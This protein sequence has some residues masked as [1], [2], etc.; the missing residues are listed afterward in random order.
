[1]HVVSIYT[2]IKI[3]DAPPKEAVI[4]LSSAIDYYDKNEIR[5]WQGKS[6]SEMTLSKSSDISQNLNLHVNQLLPQGGEQVKY[7][8]LQWKIM[9]KQIFIN[10]SH[11]SQARSHVETLQKL[12]G[13]LR[14]LS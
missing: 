2:D 5:V 10:S 6:E 11:K 9:G 13:F 3:N 14:I 12:Y 8:K 1:M 7:D 4:F